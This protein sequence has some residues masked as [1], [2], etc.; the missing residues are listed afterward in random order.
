MV[1]YKISRQVDS[2]ALG[3]SRCRQT[4]GS[5]RGLGRL[6]PTRSAVHSARLF[7]APDH[8]SSRSRRLFESLH[9]QQIRLLRIG[10][11]F[12]FAKF[13]AEGAIGPESEAQILNRIRS[14]L[15]RNSHVF[16]NSEPTP[17]DSLVPPRRDVSTAFIVVFRHNQASRASTLADC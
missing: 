15:T 6:G 14:S 17:T 4:R 7:A 9:A 5:L 13:T 10:R 11:L 2:S 1:K 8:N 3:T 12:R 16:A